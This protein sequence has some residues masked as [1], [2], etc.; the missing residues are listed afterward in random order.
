MDSKPIKVLLVEDDE[1]YVCLLRETLGSFHA[2]QFELIWS[3]DLG[4]ALLRLEQE[5]FDVVLLDLTLPDSQGLATFSRLHQKAPTLPMIVLTGVED[6]NQAL[7]AVREGAQEYLV[8]G[9]VHGKM[10]MR[11][12][13]YAIERK[14][15]EQALRER[16]EFFRLISE[17]MSDLIA[18][19]D[20]NGKRLYNSPSYKGLFGDPDTLRGTSSFVEIHPEDKARVQR[21]FRETVESGEGQRTEFRFVLPDRSVRYLESVGSVIKDGNGQTSKVVVVSRDVTENR[22]AVERLRQ[23]EALY[24]SLVESLPQN[25]FRKSLDGRFTFANQRFCLALNTSTEQVLGKTDFDFFP[26]ELAEK[27][28]ADDRAVINSGE[29]FDTIE[30][31]Q[32]I[33]GKRMDVHVV[34]IPIRDAAGQITG[35]QGIYWDITKQKQAE[36]RLIQ[37][38]E[39]LKRSHEELKSAQLQL[40]QAAKLESV[41]TLAAGVAHEVKNPLQTI[42]MGLDYFTRAVPSDNENVSMVLT[43]MRSAVK[44]ADT[45]IRGLLQFSATNTPDAKDEKF[46]AVLAQALLLV[47]Y[48]LTRSRIVLMGDLA[49]VLPPVRLD[50]IKM[51]QV[52]INL[53]MNAIHAMPNGG[54]L[55]VTTRAERIASP[56]EEGGTVRFRP[57]DTVVIAEVRDTGTGIPEEVLPKIFDPFFTTKPTGVGT[58]L[59]LPVT[60]KI[61]E[62]HGGTITIRNDPAGG[63]RVTIM[64]KAST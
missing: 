40:I 29:I 10:L 52:F 3:P 11:V 21:I 28:Q 39:D 24:H 53:F 30:E 1:V 56:V 59:G 51:E 20:R 31:N 42:L 6:E 38:L 44:R 54:K 34:K 32:P 37:T 47:R 62:L 64:L 19:L 18:V 22:L 14:Q 57:G 2:A 4:D 63:V 12:M 49:E 33:G 23:S 9:Q 13:R 61:I 60:K 46:N 25:I 27:Y 5:V 17:N 50:K 45:I 26:R 35:I 7:E 15:V 8:K 16:E 41:G 36:E 43:D 58:G 55:T 48:E